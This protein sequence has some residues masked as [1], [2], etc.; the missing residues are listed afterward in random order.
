MRIRVA[1]PNRNDKLDRAAQA[2]RRM[3][4][5]VPA[6]YAGHYGVSHPCQP[7]CERGLALRLNRSS[8]C[9]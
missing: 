4:A 2:R 7:P 8:I 5:S 6:C 9:R 1:Q 3:T